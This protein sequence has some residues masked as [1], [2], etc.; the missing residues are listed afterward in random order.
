MNIPVIEKMTVST[1]GVP[2]VKDS[3]TVSLVTGV[4]CHR[5]VVR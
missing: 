3:W 1:Y 2:P 5:G 4:L